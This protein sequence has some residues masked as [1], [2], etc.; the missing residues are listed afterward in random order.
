MNYA[1]SDSENKIRE[2]IHNITF[3]GNTVSAD[4]MIEINQLE[5]EKLLLKQLIAHLRHENLLL[6]RRLFSAGK[7]EISKDKCA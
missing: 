3:V 1:K 5:S 7:I 6:K 4:P 2:I